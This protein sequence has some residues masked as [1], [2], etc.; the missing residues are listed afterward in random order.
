MKC[1]LLM[2]VDHE[3]KD[4]KVTRAIECLQ[5][6]CAWWDTTRKACAMEHISYSLRII[7]EELVDI[8]HTMF[9]AKE[10]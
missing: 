7:A 1:P 5:E 4:G 3:S 2:I 9:Q 6:G 10:K 8:R